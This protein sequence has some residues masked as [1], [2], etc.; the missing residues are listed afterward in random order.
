MPIRVN[1]HG[2]CVQEGSHDDTVL[3]GRRGTLAVT[4]EEG[5]WAAW[6][7]DLVKPHV[8]NNGWPAWIEVLAT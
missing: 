4:F 5:A 8:A 6:L 2:Q 1:S 3:A 7:Y